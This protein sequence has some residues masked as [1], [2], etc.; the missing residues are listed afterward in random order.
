M[1]KIVILLLI[2]VFVLTSC[3][4]FSKISD[5]PSF[6]VLTRYQI[7]NGTADVKV[8]RGN[9]M[10][11]LFGYIKKNKSGKIISKKSRFNCGMAPENYWDYDMV[12]HLNNGSERTFSLLNAGCSFLY[13]E[14]DNI[15]LA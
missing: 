6:I 10:N 15:I 4:R 9:D 11:L 3:Q 13:D 8:L 14:K 1:T 2:A 12:I 5:K 7:N